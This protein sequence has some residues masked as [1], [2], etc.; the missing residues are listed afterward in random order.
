LQTE[1]YCSGS[2]QQELYPSD[3][4]NF[5]IPILDQNIQSQIA[6]NV[7]QSFSL[8]RQSERLLDTAK[9]AVE[10]A[11][12]QGEDKATELLSAGVTA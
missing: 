8:K 11:I 10:L 1:R 5:V 3:I 2:A 6:T 7:R 12:E 4:G 9:Q